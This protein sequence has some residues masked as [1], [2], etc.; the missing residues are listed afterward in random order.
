VHDKD[1]ADGGLTVG[2]KSPTTG[3]NWG[4]EPLAYAYLGK[5][6]YRDLF[7]KDPAKTFG[8]PAGLAVL[9]LYD[10]LTPYWKPGTQTLGIDDADRAFAQ[11][12]AG[13]DLGGTFTLASLRQNGMNPAD[14]VTFGI[15]AAAGGATGDLKLAPVALTGLAVSAQAKQ[16]D[17]ALKWLRFLSS[18][19]QAGA[20]AQASLD[21]PGTS[22]ARTPDACSGRSWPRCGPCSVT[23][24]P[25]PTTRPIP[26]CSAPPT[27]TS[28]LAKR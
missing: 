16:P 7:G 5:Q 23:P 19:E 15:P 4:L 14:V 18:P 28:H 1:P 3:F 6:G 22:S 9:K 12:K 24:R 2:L 10:Q 27:R 25:G 11:G 8:G 13:F 26:R 20:F 21:L 17:A